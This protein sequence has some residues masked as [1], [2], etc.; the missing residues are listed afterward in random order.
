MITVEQLVELNS[1]ERVLGL[2]YSGCLALTFRSKAVIRVIH[3]LLDEVDEAD[4]RDL[5]VHS[6]VELGMNALGGVVRP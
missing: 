4:D 2:F 5:S 6:Q 1:K 3:P